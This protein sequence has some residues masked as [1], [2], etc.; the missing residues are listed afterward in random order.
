MKKTIRFYLTMAMAKCMIA[1]MRLLGKSATNLPG[2]AAL[3]L[4]PTFLG[5]L[6]KPKTIIGVTGT[7]GKTTVTN[8]IADVLEDNGYIFAS[9]RAGGNVDTGI[10][11]ALIKESTLSGKARKD[12][13][14]LEIDE[15]SANRVYP[16]LQP[17]YLVCTNL[18]RD[19]AKRNAHPEFISGVLNTYIPAATKLVLNGDDLISGRLAPDNNRVY[20]G[21]D[22]LEG[23]TPIT[24]NLIKDIV[25]CPVCDHPLEYEFVRYNHI[26]RAHC[27]HC[28]FG[29]PEVNYTVTAVDK[30][31]RLVSMQTPAGEESYRLVGDNITD[32]YNMAAAIALLREF[33]LDYD[34]LKASYQNMKI[35][36]TRF[37]QESVGGKII[38]DNLAKGQNPIAC[39]R[40]FDFVRKTPGKKAVILVID[41]VHDAK[42]STE[43]TTWIYECDFEF[44]RDD[45]IVQII[46]GGKRAWDFQMRLLMADVEKERIACCEDERETPRMLKT[47]E[48]DTIF[49]LHDICNNAIAQDIKAELRSLCAKGGDAV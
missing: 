10:T 16:Y 27:P 41:D 12:L 25:A 19:S 22:H 44:L 39:S 29:S 14:V 26:G 31:E 3:I 6:D 28:G 23:E 38:V 47:A 45:D 37:N 33:G 1:L 35:V 5:Q 2:E 32:L 43:N 11:T 46:V 9:N 40:V 21:I 17:T 15:R 4:C 24:D 48:V 49:L 34:R 20:F 36:E 8:M 30:G 42:Y 18:F 7:N 13:A